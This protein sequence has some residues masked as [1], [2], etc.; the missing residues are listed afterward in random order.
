YCA[1]LASGRHYAEPQSCPIPLHSMNREVFS[2]KQ[3]SRPGKCTYPV[4]NSQTTCLFLTHYSGKLFLGG[5]LDSGQRAG[6]LQG[7]HIDAATGGANLVCRRLGE[8][9]RLHGQLLR[10]I[11]VAE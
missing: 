2:S 1:D 10:E 6:Q 8:A 7:Q 11:T 3:E 4:F 5:Q 9:V